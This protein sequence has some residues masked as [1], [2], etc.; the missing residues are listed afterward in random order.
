MKDCSK[1][2]VGY[3]FNE[4]FIYLVNIVFWTPTFNSFFKF[5]NEFGIFYFCRNFSP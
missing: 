5:P 1:L 4:Q 3:M 2:E